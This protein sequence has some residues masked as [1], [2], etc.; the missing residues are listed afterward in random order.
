MARV[1]H[2]EIPADDPERAVTFYE[3]VFGWKIAKWNGPEDYWLAGT[4]EQ[5]QPGIDG[6]ITR[7]SSLQTVCNTV[8]VP[9]LDDSLGQIA[10]AG[11][12]V[13]TPKMAVP[14]VGY[15][16]YCQDTE[17]NQFGVMQS[18]PSAR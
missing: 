4:G 9:S 5:G 8:D 18:D 3:Q 10:E 13:L 17:G 2:F 12:R 6:A 14:G 15:M 16:A 11:G 7:R 1:I